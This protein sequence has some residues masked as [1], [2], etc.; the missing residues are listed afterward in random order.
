MV[1]GLDSILRLLP[2]LTFTRLFILL[3]IHPF[4]QQIITEHLSLCQGLLKVLHV[5]IF[6]FI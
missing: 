4:I 3:I 2:V 1:G 6:L 5:F